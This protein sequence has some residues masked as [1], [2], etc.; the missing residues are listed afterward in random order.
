[1]DGGAWW[2]TVHGVT[3]SRTRLSNFTSLSLSEIPEDRLSTCEFGKWEHPVTHGFTFVVL[4]SLPVVINLFLNCLRVIIDM[5][6]APHD[7]LIH[8]CVFPPGKD[9]LL[10]HHQ[11]T[12]Q[13]RKSPLV[14]HYHPIHISHA[15]F[16]NFFNDVPLKKNHLIFKYYERNLELCLI[17]S[18]DL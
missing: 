3:K 2:A 9:I 6:S 13:N 8:Q 11:T 10:H 16:T 15:N 5:T 12:L 1:M 14:Q 18:H 17:F 7:A 4:S